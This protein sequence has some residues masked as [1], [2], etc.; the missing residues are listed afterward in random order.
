MKN[1][2]QIQSQGLEIKKRFPSCCLQT[3]DEMA[4]R[5]GRE[6]S[7]GEKTISFD[8]GGLRM[9]TNYSFQVLPQDLGQKFV[10]RPSQIS[11]QTKGCKFN[12]GDY[13]VQSQFNFPRCDPTS[14]HHCI[15]R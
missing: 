10:A 6:T 9:S 2:R 4:A 1:L 15:L 12:S 5:T 3:V 7:Q 13:F 8:I 14:H 11:L